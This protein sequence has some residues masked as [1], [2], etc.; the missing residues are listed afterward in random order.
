MDLITFRDFAQQPILTL[1]AQRL[2]ALYRDGDIM[3]RIY[4]RI[5]AIVAWTCKRIT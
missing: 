5:H 1:L 3:H 4:R 2:I